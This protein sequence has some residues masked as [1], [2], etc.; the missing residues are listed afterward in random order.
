MNIRGKILTPVIGLILLSATLIGVIA[1]QNTKNLNHVQQI[2]QEALT[3]QQYAFSLADELVVAQELVESAMAMTT[4]IT[5]EEY[6]RKF[7]ELDERLSKKL[8]DAIALSLNKKMGAATMQAR[9]NYQVWKSSTEVLLGITPSD[10]VP[11]HEKINRNTANL[12]KSI[13]SIV[14]TTRHAS[15]EIIS[16]SSEKAFFVNVISITAIAI[17]SIAGFGIAW[18]SANNISKPVTYLTEKMNSLTKGDLDIDLDLPDRK[19][20]IGKIFDAVVIFRGNAIQQR[21]LEEQNL[22]KL[23]TEKVI[24]VKKEKAITNFRSALEQDMARLHNQSTEMQ[25]SSLSLHR[26]ADKA[27]QDAQ[28]A[29][30]AAESSRD[31]TQT[32]AIATK[33]LIVSINTIGEQSSRANDLVNTTVKT[34]QN[35]DRQVT[36]LSNSAE[37]IGQVLEL[38]RDI[39]DKTNLLALNATIEAARAG[40][41]GRGFAVVATEVKSLASQTAKATED[42]S[43]HITGVQSS[44]TAAVDAINAI[45]EAVQEVSSLTQLINQSVSEQQ[46]AT[47]SIA[48]A[49]EAAHGQSETAANSSDEVSASILQTTNEASTV[50][51]SSELLTEVTNSLSKEVDLF[52]TTVTKLDNHA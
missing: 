11:T 39:A 24:Q 6:E 22:K 20:E 30:S 4:F 40:E 18:W 5:Q 23:E 33:Q 25:A 49:A 29:G 12:S 45:S 8:D 46:D 9:N 36:A 31:N 47:L 38:I 37:Q 10:L 3:A 41:M 7:N 2:S 34:A 35:T 52:L 15:H 28:S 21:E 26:M 1:W 13:K 16:Q 50:S 17:L 14:E 27:T 51:K 43:N 32:V 44:T 48:N 19:D 42:I